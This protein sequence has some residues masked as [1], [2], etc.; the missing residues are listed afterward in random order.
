VNLDT[1]ER[2]LR[3]KLAGLAMQAMIAKMPVTSNMKDP[4]GKAKQISNEEMHEMETAIARGAYSYAD[5]ML[6]ERAK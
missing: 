1:Y 4:L 2:K 3:D 5:A 6:A